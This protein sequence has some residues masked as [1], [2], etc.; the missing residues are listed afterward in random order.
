MLKGLI[1]VA[2]GIVSL[3]KPTEANMVDKGFLVEDCALQGPHT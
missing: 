1:G 3:I 2:P